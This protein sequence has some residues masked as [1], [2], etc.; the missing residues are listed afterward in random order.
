MEEAVQILLTPIKRSILHFFGGEIKLGMD[1]TMAAI[2]VWNKEHPEI[3]V[4]GEYQG[5]GW[6]FGKAGH[7]ICRRA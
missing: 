1:A 4:E 7:A 5:L 3:Q 2:K 6:V